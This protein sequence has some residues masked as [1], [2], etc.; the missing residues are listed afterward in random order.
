MSNL[1]GRRILITGANRGLGLEMVKQ[2]LKDYHPEKIFAACRKPEEAVELK[3]LAEKNS[4]VHVLQLGN[5]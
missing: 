1:I 2:L 3:S 5:S 4:A